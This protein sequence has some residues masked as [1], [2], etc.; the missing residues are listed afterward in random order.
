[1]KTISLSILTAVCIF[2]I[3]IRVGEPNT[4]LVKYKSTCDSLRVQ[5][6]SLY[7]EILELNDQLE[8][9]KEEVSMLKV[10]KVN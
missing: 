6:D 9:L 2:V 3:L 5:N 1:M 10:E 8:H 4:D 7:Y